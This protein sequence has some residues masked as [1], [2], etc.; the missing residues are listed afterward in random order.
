MAAE[1]AIGSRRT[2]PVVGNRSAVATAV[3]KAAA[4]TRGRAANACSLLDV[5]T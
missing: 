3:A 2:A 4:G 5:P 1:M